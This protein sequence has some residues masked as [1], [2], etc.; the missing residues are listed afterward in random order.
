MQNTLGEILQATDASGEGR[1]AR[2]T[3]TGQAE[4]SD[5][6]DAADV[7]TSGEEQESP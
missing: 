6:A 3:G 4:T 7:W 5:K 2:S 1:S